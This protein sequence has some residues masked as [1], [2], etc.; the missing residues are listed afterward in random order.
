MILRVTDKPS[1]EELQHSLLLDSP[2][3]STAGNSVGG[4]DV[5]R[6]GPVPGDWQLTEPE[7]SP[8]GAGGQRK[9]N[10]GVCLLLLPLMASAAQRVSI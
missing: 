8:A 1:G 7:G 5:Q 6:Q 3:P 10:P 9:P 4:G 2:H